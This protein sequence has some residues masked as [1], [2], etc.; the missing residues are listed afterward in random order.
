MGLARAGT[1]QNQLR[2]F[3]D[4]INERIENIKKVRWLSQVVLQSTVREATIF[5]KSVREEQTNIEPMICIPNVKCFLNL[6]QK[7]EFAN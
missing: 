5:V 1:F 3:S 4:E 2:R 7:F 6:Q